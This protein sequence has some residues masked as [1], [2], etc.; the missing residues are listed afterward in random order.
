MDAIEKLI[1]KSEI[2]ENLCRYARGVDRR[3]W[4]AV[5]ECYH[6]DATDWHGE[7]QGSPGG[8]IEWVSA[9][10]A[11]IPFSM[12]FLGNCLIEFDDA[13]SAH[14]ETY[15]VAISR[16]ETKTNSENSEGRDTEIF[17]RYVDR[18][19]KRADNVWRVASRQVVYDSSRTLQST[20]HLRELQGVMGERSRKDAVYRT[21]RAAE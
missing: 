6:D 16:R 5:R 7:F 15:F 19:E 13:R 20:H 1:A 8:F 17:G 18:F 21:V 9:R 3:D 4:P 10:H 2:E 11:Q 14:A 12:H